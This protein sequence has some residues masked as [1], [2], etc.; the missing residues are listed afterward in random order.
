MTVPDSGAA[1]AGETA[2]PGEATAPGGAAPG[3]AVPPG[4]HRAR[5]AATGTFLIVGLVFSSYFVRV[6]SIKLGH[7]LSDGQLGLM[8]VVPSLAALVAM[9]L[10]G[11]LVARFGSAPV[12]R[13][14]AAALPVLLLGI[15]LAGDPFQLVLALLL[16]GAVDGLV[17]VSM[18]AH[19]IAVERTLRRPI[20]SG[21]HA[22]WSI[23][24]M[25]GSLVGGFALRAGLSLTQH[26]LLLGAVT[27]VFALVIGRY[28]LPAS[29]DR[30]AVPA[31][32]RRARVS[33]LAGWTPRVVALGVVG[34]VVLL[35]EGAVGNWSGVFLHEDRGATLAT[36]SLGYIAFTVCQ[37]GTRLVGD[38]LHQRFGALALVRWSGAFTVAGLATV[39]ASPAPA[40][41]VAGFALM[42]LGL[43]VLLPI[44]FSAVG[45]SGAES[46]AAGAAAALSKFT[47]LTYTGLLAGPPLIGWLAQAF[48]L[49]ATLGGLLVLMAGVTLGARITV[50]ADRSGAA[51][52]GT[53]H[54]GT[55]RAGA[56]DAGKAAEPA[57]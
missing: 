9:Q 53:G 31:G 20:M 44:V 56:E 30:L 52:P 38:R 41:A 32:G 16:F 48:G 45:H 19:A 6:P 15:A 22:A 40:L 25:T 21:C 34:A 26:Y 54:S 3:A 55:D 43:A 49:P 47:T 12:A 51:H 24:A 7:G 4:A 11:G 2:V 8:L 23:G 33:W 17:D 27:L 36:A 5:W 1:A 13:L 18:N 10:T 39:I 46:D 57:P 35:C 28:M 14:S 29:A 37:T 50:S 42:G